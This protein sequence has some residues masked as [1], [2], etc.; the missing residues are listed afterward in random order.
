MKIGGQ[1]ALDRWV[2]AQ[3]ELVYCVLQNFDMDTIKQEVEDKK[4]TGDLDLV[5]KKYCE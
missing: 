3:E 1:D 5:F 2:R 4:E